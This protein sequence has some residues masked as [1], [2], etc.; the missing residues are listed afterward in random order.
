MA[1]AITEADCQ[2]ALAAQPDLQLYHVSSNWPAGGEL[3]EGGIMEQ[4]V[5]DNEIRSS[6]NK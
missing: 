6:I 1:G 3:L 2:V 5:K 4:W